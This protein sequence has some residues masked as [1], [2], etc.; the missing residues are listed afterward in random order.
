MDMKIF[1]IERSKLPE[2]GYSQFSV[3]T[4]EELILSVSKCPNCG[5][6]DIVEDY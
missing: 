2:V 1:E 6:E 4:G 5:S 3:I